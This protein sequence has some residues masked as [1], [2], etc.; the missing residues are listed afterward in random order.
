MLLRDKVVIVTG[1]GGGLGAGIARVCAREGAK[2]V[3]ADIRGE[4]AMEVAARRDGA[5]GTTS[6][7][8]GPRA[9]A[10]GLR[11]SS[12]RR[13]GAACRRRVA[14]TTRHSRTCRISA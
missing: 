10:A 7:A 4:W 12:S 2:V 5:R 11:C 14:I 13:G 1:A 3:V 8:T 6:R 9:S